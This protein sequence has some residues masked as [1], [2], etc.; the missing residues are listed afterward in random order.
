VEIDV[1]HVDGHLVVFHDNRLE[2][3]TNG[4]GLLLDQ[5]FDYLRSLD[6]GDGERIPTLGEVC[7][8]VAGRAGVNIEL[9]GPGTAEP[10]ADFLGKLSD[11][12][13][14]KDSF[15]VSSFARRELVEFRRRDTR[16]K[17]GVLIDSAPGEGTALAAGL[18]AFSVHPRIDL[19]TPEFVETAHAHGLKVYVYTVNRAPD[20]DRM[21]RLGADGVFTNFPERVTAKYRQPD[22]N[23]AWGCIAGI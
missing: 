3:T 11:E 21:F 12:G 14:P 16:M 5:S 17:L 8:T 10:V 4:K 18:S 1:Y 20:I 2:R 7:E 23:R 6:A 19:T 22:L 13:T 15:L 9:K